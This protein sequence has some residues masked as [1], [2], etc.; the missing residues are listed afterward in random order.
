MSISVTCKAWE[1]F[2][3]FTWRSHHPLMM[4]QLLRSDPCTR[5][6]PVENS[7]LS[8]GLARKV[9]STRVLTQGIFV[10]R[11]IS[12]SKHLFI[13]S[14]KRLSVVFR[15][16]FNYAEI[17]VKK[18]TDTTYRKSNVHVVLY[19]TFGE[20]EGRGFPLCRIT[21]PPHSLQGKEVVPLVT[22]PERRQNSK[23]LF[24]SHRRNLD[25]SR[26]NYVC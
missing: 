4:N 12:Y 6:P 11:M 23:C 5:I 24:R 15:V 3:C 9:R 8:V 2:C 10:L 1:V 16:V 25:I 19:S 26:R 21:G 22:Q 20:A 17:T 18:I 7:R 14:R 13:K